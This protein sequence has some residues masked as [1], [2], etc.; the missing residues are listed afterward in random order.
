MSKSVQ[1]QFLG[2]CSSYLNRSNCISETCSL[3]FLTPL[4]F[5]IV[6][7]RRKDNGRDVKRILKTN[8]RKKW[9]HKEKNLK[10][11]KRVLVGDADIDFSDEGI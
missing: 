3:T 4:I 10:F 1:F 9:W 5:N 8:A 6:S 7:G 2:L 11:L